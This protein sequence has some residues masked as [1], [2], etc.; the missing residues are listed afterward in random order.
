MIVKPYQAPQTNNPLWNPWLLQSPEA[1]AESEPLWYREETPP[2]AN[3]ETR[4]STSSSPFCAAQ[5]SDSNQ[6]ILD[7]LKEAN[8]RT[9]K[10]ISDGIPCSPKAIDALFSN[11]CDLR[12]ANEESEHYEFLITT[13]TDVFYELIRSKTSSRKWEEEDSETEIS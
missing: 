8:K 1:E 11:L 4:S 5:L 6:W 9:L 13:I 3:Y 2:V 7:S 10:S 12:D